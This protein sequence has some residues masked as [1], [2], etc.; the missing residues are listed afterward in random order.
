MMPED[1]DDLGIETFEEVYA[2]ANQPK[3]QQQKQPPPEDEGYMAW[4]GRKAKEGLTTAADYGAFGPAMMGEENR[5]FSTRTAAR[6]GETLVGLPGDIRDASKALGGWLGEKGRWLIG[7][8]PLTDEQRAEI[9]EQLKPATYDLVGRLVEA[10][11]TSSDLREGVTRRFTDDWLEPQNRWEE[12]ADNVASDFAALAIPIKGKIPFARAIGQAVI[13]NAGGEVAREFGGEKAEAYTKMG[14][15]FG[16]GMMGG[17][18]QG[19]KKYMKGLYDDMRATVPQG[20]EI[21]A[22]RLAR[23][24][25]DIE[26]TLMKGD[27]AAAS[28]SQAFQKVKAVRDKIKSGMIDVEEV[29]ELTKDTNEAIFGLGELKRGQNQLYKIREALHD[30]TKEYGATIL[31]PREMAVCQ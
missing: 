18:R 30:A 17:G 3:Q 14:L 23:K 16:M 10:L 26:R 12:F 8:E 9:E 4:A 6:I 2:R 19:V 22:T 24:M 28:K 21:S 31:L 29:L 1:D 5:R 11:P 13:A 27:P 20:A 15:L 7:K 25:D